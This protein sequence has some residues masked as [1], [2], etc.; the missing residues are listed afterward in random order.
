MLVASF[1]LAALQLAGASPVVEPSRRQSSGLLGVLASKKKLTFDAAGQFK[2]LSL[3]DMHFGERNGDGSW[4]AWGVTQ[5]TNT[6]RV[7]AT[8]LDQ[9]KPNYV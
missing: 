3:S 2:V 6:Q 4:A 7:H 9:E 8:V 5:D 1:L